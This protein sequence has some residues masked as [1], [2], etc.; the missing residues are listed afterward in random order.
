MVSGIFTFFKKYFP[1]FVLLLIISLFFYKTIF[2]G[3]VPFPG[4][5]LMG[6]YEPYKSLSSGIPHKGQGADIIRQLYPWK[7]FSIESIKNGVFPLWDPYIFS[8]TPHFANLQSGTLYPLNILFFILPFVSAWA[9]YIILQFVLAFCF[10]YLYLKEIGLKKIPSI[11]GS[12][13][14]SFSAFFTVWG[15][16]GNVGHSLA[17]L[18]LLLFAVEKLL[19]TKRVGWLLLLA[20]S[21]ALS[22]F[23]GYVQLTMYML[24]LG[25]CYLAFRYYADKKKERKIYILAAFGLIV[26]VLISA[27]QLF[28]LY[29][30][31]GRSLR[32]NYSYK[33]LL[34]I[35][36]LPLR[37]IVTLLVPD[38]FGNPATNNYFLGGSSLERAMNVGVWPFIF[39]VF[40]GFSKKNSLKTFF[41]IT[42][43]LSLVSCLALPPIA[44]FHSVGI[45]FLSTGVPTRVL[46][47]FAF[48]LAVLGAFGLQEF[49]E[50]KNKKKMLLIMGFFAALFMI[51]WGITFIVHSPGLLISRRNLMIPSALF[52]V[53]SILLFVKQKKLSAVVLVSLTVF[54]LFYSFQKFNSFVPPAYIYPST[55]INAQL[56]KIQGVDRYW[57]YGSANIDA[58]FQT[59]EKTFTTEGYDPLFSKRYGEFVAASQT[60][61]IPKDVP[62]SVANI[63][64]GYGVNDLKENPYRKRALNITGVTYIL[65]KKEDKGIDSAFDEK[66]FRLIWE[67][68][69]WQ[70]YENLGVL[71]RVKMFGEDEVLKP[72]GQIGLLYDPKFNYKETLILDN[73]F[74]FQVKP[75][76]SAS[77]KI[78]SY[79]PNEI[80]IKTA[81]KEQQFLFLSDNFFPGWYADID[82]TVFP[83]I[84][85]AD[86]AFRAV[87]VPAGEHTV[88]MYYSPPSF[89]VGLW[90]SVISFISLIVAV[91]FTKMRYTYD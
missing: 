66:E 43:V 49:L 46:A 7:Y 75:D 54:E 4:D 39:A 1:V 61:N 80:I 55:G 57:G 68:N 47:I 13:A 23:A 52:I 31:L 56:R 45:P 24:I 85:I 60:G 65:N 58:N 22:I 73:D 72:R 70:I 67:Q 86:Y 88:R 6:N 18:P 3:L 84:L 79:G 64:H 41:G 37:A 38:F 27:I 77:A 62:R 26:G 42:A 9:A 53:G 30:F 5:L 17:F 29:E 10:T 78:I 48:S 28:P 91:V 20:A 35:R 25:F 40:A 44:L 81:A 19:K 33:D 21:V 90:I 50:S 14:F 51:L 82:H 12:A 83:P 2:L 59:L 74:G 76:S 8:G 16:Y 71:P 34:D 89:W 15:E 11:F 87:P 36:L 32:S 63:V 69:G